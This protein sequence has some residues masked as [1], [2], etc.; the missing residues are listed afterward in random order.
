[1]ATL[2][3]DSTGRISGRF[4]TPTGI[5]AGEKEVVFIGNGGSKG[6]AVFS[7]QGTL[8]RKVLQVE[9]TI[10]DTYWSSPPPPNPHIK[11]PGLEIIVA[12]PTPADPTNQNV[13]NM[14]I[15]MASDQMI[16]KGNEGTG[17]ALL[18]YK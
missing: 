3:A 4:T 6:S 7:G 17:Q 10:T 9:T 14:V 16:S 15:E 5:S 8:Q 13:A 11:E 12:V 1:M 2:I 18:W